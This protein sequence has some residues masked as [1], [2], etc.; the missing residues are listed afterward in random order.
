M[1]RESRSKQMKW[2]TSEYPR[3][4]TANKDNPE[5]CF[6]SARLSWVWT[7]FEIQGSLNCLSTQ[8]FSQRE[9]IENISEK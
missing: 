6:Y 1:Q 3:F 7:P 2:K 9:L 8:S 5:K 4:P